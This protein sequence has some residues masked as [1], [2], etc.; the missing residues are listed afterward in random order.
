ML[1]LPLVTRTEVG[2][3]EKTAKGERVEGALVSSPQSGRPRVVSGAGAV[4]GIVSPCRH[5]CISVLPAL[6]STWLFL[7]CPVFKPPPPL[8]LSVCYL[9]CVSVPLSL[10][11][12]RVTLLLFP[13]CPCFLSLILDPLISLT[14]LSLP[15]FSPSLLSL[16]LP[17]QEIFS[18]W[19]G[20]RWL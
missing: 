14:S 17:E 1:G 4:L 12:P 10:L 15:L 13:R 18:S 19:M 7:S 16:R 2:G 3:P 8:N 11:L 20:A 5:R 6:L 9:A